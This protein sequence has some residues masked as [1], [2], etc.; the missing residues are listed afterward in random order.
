VNS[1][2]LFCLRRTVPAGSSNT[3]RSSHVKNPAEDYWPILADR[4]M[5]LS[6]LAR[7]FRPRYA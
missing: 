7:S 6:V 5:T 2:A 4:V 1:S 3:K